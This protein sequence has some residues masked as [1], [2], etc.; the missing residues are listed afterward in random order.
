MGRGVAG[1]HD[2]SFRNAYFTNKR[3]NQEGKYGEY[4]VVLHQPPTCPE[5]G[6]QKFGKTDSEVTVLFLFRGGFAVTAATGFLTMFKLI[7]R[8]TSI[9]VSA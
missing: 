3:V 9:V 8:R 5:C 2:A 7:K 6:Q 4:G 1:F